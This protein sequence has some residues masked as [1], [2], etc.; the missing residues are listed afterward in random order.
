MNILTYIDLEAGG[1][2]SGRHAGILQSHGWKRLINPP[3]A[4]QVW[5]HSVHRG[6]IT[7]NSKRGHWEHE[8]H[9]NNV[10]VKGRTGKELS[11]YLNRLG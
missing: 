3:H 8:T 6:H 4:V 9:V 7:V 1:P 2:G 11:S 10:R 5:E